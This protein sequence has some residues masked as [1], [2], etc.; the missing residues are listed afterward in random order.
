MER[1][2]GVGVWA[3]PE[4]LDAFAGLPVVQAGRV[5][6]SNIIDQELRKRC[7]TVF[8]IGIGTGIMYKPFLNAI[9]NRQLSLIG[10]DILPEMIEA[11][12]KLIGQNKGCV[13]STQDVREQFLLPNQSVDIVEASLVLH[14]ILKADELIDIFKRIHAVLK[15]GGKF[16]LYDIDVDIGSH[17][18]SKLRTLEDRYIQV[19]IDLNTAEFVFRDKQIKKRQKILD[20]MSRNDQEIIKNMDIQTCNP[21]IMEMELYKPDLKHVIM[22][23]VSNAR[24]GLEWHRSIKD[25][26]EL[27][28][29][30]FNKTSSVEVFDSKIIKKEFQQVLDRPFLMVVTKK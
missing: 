25:W 10:I 21:L 3:N 15:P 2:K 20:P 8:S 26:K 23:N 14:H 13:L 1:Q 16:V 19:N 28:G 27:I 12:N 6:I 9:N 24:Q 18:E 11:C 7:T 29:M 4:F 17:I 5:M 30:S 22:D